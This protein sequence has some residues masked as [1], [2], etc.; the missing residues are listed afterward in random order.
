[1]LIPSTLITAL[2]SCVSFVNGSDNFF[3]D[4][5]KHV[6]NYAIGVM[7]VISTGLQTFQATCGI[8]QKIKAYTAVGTKIQELLTHIEFDSEYSLED[9]D[10]KLVLIQKDCAYTIPLWANDMYMKQQVSQV[11]QVSQVP[12]VPQVTQ[13][14]DSSSSDFPRRLS[15]SSDPIVDDSEV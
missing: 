8:E 14:Q 4:D 11:S 1:M 12:Q 7:T 2:T 9:L 3:T 5:T 6:V 15:S 10:D 13:Q